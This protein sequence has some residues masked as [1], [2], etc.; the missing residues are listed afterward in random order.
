[1]SILDHKMTISL[2]TKLHCRSSVCMCD[3]RTNHSLH[4][5]LVAGSKIERSICYRLPVPVKIGTVNHDTRDWFLVPVGWY[6]KLVPETGQCVMGFRCRVSAI[7]AICQPSTQT[8]LHNQLPSRYH[9]HKTSY[10]NF[11]LKICCHG[12]NP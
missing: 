3:S 10:S 4:F 5:V 6:H 9:S 1:V 7:S 8:P 12:N 2:V 11:S